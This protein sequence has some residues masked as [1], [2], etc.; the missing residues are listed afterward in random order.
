MRSPSRRRRQPLVP[1][2]VRIHVPDK[3]SHLYDPATALT[4]DKDP[5]NGTQPKTQPQQ[6]LRSRQNF[7]PS[8][9]RHFARAEHIKRRPE[10]TPASS[11][12]W[13]NI[14][15]APPRRTEPQDSLSRPSR[16][17]RLDSSSHTVT[18]Q[19]RDRLQQRGRTH[20]FGTPRFSQQLLHKR[21]QVCSTS[22]R[23]RRLSALRQTISARASL[24]MKHGNRVVY[25]SQPVTSLLYLSDSSSSPASFRPLAPD[26]GE[27]LR[28]TTSF[29]TIVS[30][31]SSACRLH[32]R[33]CPLCTVRFTVAGQILRMGKERCPAWLLV[34]FSAGLAHVLCG[35]P[36]LSLTIA[37]HAGDPPT[38]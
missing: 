8:L 13:T 35:L 22:S 38:S 19:Q 7:A 11:T 27:S 26:S 18:V 33:I 15:E 30:A 14:K 21:L 36:L 12:P 5:I 37:W 2:R 25:L 23:G 28:C 4:F 10:L 6:L 1:N 9:N 16:T 20:V 24:R 29:V 32:S 31:F 34:T 3:A 17:Q